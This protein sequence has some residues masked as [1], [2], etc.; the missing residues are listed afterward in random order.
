MYTVTISVHH[1][2]GRNDG[3]KFRIENESGIAKASLNSLFADDQRILY[4]YKE[5]PQNHTTINMTCE[6]YNM[7]SA[8]LR[9][10]L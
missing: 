1:L 3:F 5:T 9:Q 4:D 6:K 7:K 2:D 10:K 8:Y